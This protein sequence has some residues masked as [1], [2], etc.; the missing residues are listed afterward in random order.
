MRVARHLLIV[1]LVPDKRGPRNIVAAIGLG[2]FALGQGIKLGSILYITTVLLFAV[3]AHY[4][5]RIGWATVLDDARHPLRT[6]RL[7]MSET[8]LP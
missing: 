4:L 7:L 3:L 2:L 5:W 8:R 1:L 6:V